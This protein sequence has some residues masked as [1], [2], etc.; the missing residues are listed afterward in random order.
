VHTQAHTCKHTTHARTH[1]RT[2]THT[3]TH[4]Q[5]LCRLLH[6]AISAEQALSLCVCKNTQC[7]CKNTSSQW[8][9]RPIEDTFY[10]G[11]IL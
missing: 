8:R 7:V 4:T 11:H 3:H 2:H 10:R 9:S 1:A 5:V 6:L